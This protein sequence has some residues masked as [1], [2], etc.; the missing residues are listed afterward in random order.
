MFSP[1][2]RFLPRSLV[3]MSQN[4]MRL[5]ILTIVACPGLSISTAAA[6]DVDPLQCVPYAR[7]VSGIQI[8]GDAHTWWD[9]ADGRYARGSRPAAGAVMAFKP[10]GAMQ[11][12][13]V[14]AISRIVDNRTV[15]LDHANWSTIDGTRG[16]IERDVMAVD[17]SDRNDWSEVRVWYTP[18]NGLGTTHY[19][20]EGFIYP[21][22]P[23]REFAPPATLPKPAVQ[24]A[25]AKTASPA[26]APALAPRAK[27]VPER[28][29]LSTATDRFIYETA[30]EPVVTESS[31]ASADPIGSLLEQL[32]E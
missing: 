22:N 18:I 8:Y 15:M 11:L 5:V 25:A 30:R 26:P 4:I 13:H 10:Q 14:A 31:Y 17:V 16:H 24:Y 32:G 27:P 1:H 20:I 23:G 29:N 19:A 28:R 3:R 9:Q 12:G 21:V 2:F 6:N 7:S